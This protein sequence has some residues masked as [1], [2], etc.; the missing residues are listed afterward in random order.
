MSKHLDIYYFIFIKKSILW[1]RKIIN[2]PLVYLAL[3][4]STFERTLSLG[5]KSLILSSMSLFSWTDTFTFFS[6]SLGHIPRKSNRSI[7]L[8]KIVYNFEGKKI[9]AK[10]QMMPKSRFLPNFVAERG[11]YLWIY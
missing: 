6:L 8:Q 4:S 10:S 3:R 11:L 1:Q 7:L 9:I 2:F 5:K